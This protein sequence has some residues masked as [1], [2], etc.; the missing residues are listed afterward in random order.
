MCTIGLKDAAVMYNFY[1]G[2]SRGGFEKCYEKTFYEQ[3]GIEFKLTETMLSYSNI[4]VIRG[5]HFQIKKPQ[6]KIV[7]VVSGAIID[8]IV[9]LRVGSSTFKKWE[10][11]DLSMENH[12]SLYVPKGFAHGFA[13]MADNTAILYQCDGIYEKELDSG[14]RFDDVNLDIDWPISK[15]VAIHSSRDMKL[16]GF[17]DYMRNPF[18]V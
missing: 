8:I 5:L 2:D 15:E 18:R 1:T 17:E 4:N 3:N 9:D 14:I 13:S 11:I 16:N 7:T 10:A 12:R 6:A